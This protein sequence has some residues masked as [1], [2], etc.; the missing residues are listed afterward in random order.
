MTGVHALDGWLLVWSADRCRI[1]SNN[2]LD[3]DP[4]LQKLQANITNEINTSSDSV[5]DFRAASLVALPLRLVPLEI[6]RY[7]PRWRFVIPQIVAVAMKIH[8]TESDVAALFLDGH[9]ELWTI[10]MLRAAFDHPLSQL[11]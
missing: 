5:L 10:E 9:I 7:G 8:P 2:E 3:S 4:E 6:K 11:L 1:L